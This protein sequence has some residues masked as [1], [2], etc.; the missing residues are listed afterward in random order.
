MNGYGYGY[1]SLEII[2]NGYGYGYGYLSMG[3]GMGM[4]TLYMGM[5]MGTGI[6]NLQDSSTEQMSNKCFWVLKPLEQSSF[7]TWDGFHT[8]IQSPREVF[9]VFKR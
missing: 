2:L 7:I 6:L 3:M 5:S 4:G 9:T 8:N 1:G